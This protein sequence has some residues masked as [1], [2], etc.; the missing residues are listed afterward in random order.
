MA[1]LA[2]DGVAAAAPAEPPTL[3]RGDAIGRYVVLER[4]GA[5]GM[6][7]VYAAYDP[8]LDRRVAIK[9][10]R[11]AVDPARAETAKVRLLREAQSL[12]KLAHP[13]VIAVHDAGTFDGQVFVAMEYVD[14]QDL[15]QWLRDERQAW[16]EI[17]AVFVAA[18]RGLAAAHA[19][20]I[21]HRDFKPENVLV[22]NDGRVRVLDFGLAHGGDVDRASIGLEVSAQLGAATIEGRDE[23]GDSELAL[24][25][26]GPASQL[27]TKLTQVGAIVGTPAYMSPEQHLGRKTDARTD[28]FSFCVALYEA[29]YRVRPFAGSTPHELMFAVLKGN[30]SDPPRASSTPAWVRRVLLRGLAID[31]DARY[32]T[33]ESLLGALSVDGRSRLRQGAIGSVV[34]LATAGTLWAAW[35]AS[36]LGAEAACQGAERKLGGIW[37]DEVRA[38]IKNAFVATERPYA[39]DAFE[40]TARYLDTYTHD[41][42]QLHTEA[43]EATAIRKEQSQEMLDR[44]MLCLD[45]RLRETKELTHLLS[46][47]DDKVVQ[48]AVAAAGQLTSL[49]PC[50]DREALALGRAPLTGE[51]AKRATEIDTILVGARQRLQVG[52]YEQALK[53]AR[54][55]LTSAQEIHMP[56]QEASALVMRGRA[57][58]QL[59]RFDDAERTLYEGMWRAEDAS[60]DTTRAQA[61]TTLVWVVGYRLERYDEIDR[62]VG[63]ARH[64]LDRAGGDV[65]VLAELHNNVG[66]AAF[67]RADWS[68]AI[69]Q[70]DETLRLRRELNPNHPEIANALTNLA[71]AH[72]RNGS[73]GLAEENLQQAQEQAEALYGPNHPRT[74]NLLHSRAHLAYEQGRFDVA[75]SLLRR[76]VLVRETSLP[77]LHVDT[78]RAIHDLGE[79]LLRTGDARAALGQFQRAAELKQLSLGQDNATIANSLAGVGRAHAALEEIAP[80][81]EALRRAD[82]MYAELG[83]T[84]ANRA[85]TQLALAQALAT[86][87]PAEARRLARAAATVYGDPDNRDV[88]GLAE[89]EALLD[90]LGG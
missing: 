32:P 74:A 17:V 10:I 70:W 31:P 47:A 26:T 21:V 84:G 28:Q 9:L 71:F 75:V 43:C 20:G 18:G 19:A 30:V 81:I 48:R 55:A 16:P 87:A 53:M 7:I 12:A 22:G 79:A 57:E 34:V 59:G 82:A 2:G 64:S 38:R 39:Q 11:A 88:E 90:R 8:E 1:T 40:T 85:E 29:L 44:Q 15:A 83:T 50:A 46:D 89:A 27:S 14:G 60:D 45:R 62:L 76:A 49:A 13:N 52:R 3:R 51:D 5:G 67:A 56:A 86:T 54:T 66:T 42:V 41:W 36:E 23:S 63:H 65:A 6:G 24:R 61:W 72:A 4:L 37:D 25:S 77:R 58:E 35:P 68:R 73:F 80:A 69:A 33:M 78:A